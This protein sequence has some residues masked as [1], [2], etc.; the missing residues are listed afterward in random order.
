MVSISPAGMISRMLLFHLVDQLLR[1]LDAGAG[2]R[3]EVQL[4]QPGVHGREKIHPDDEDAA[5]C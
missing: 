2:G 4:H 1:L 3:P 5:R